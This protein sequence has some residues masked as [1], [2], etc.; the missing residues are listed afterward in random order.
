[1]EVNRV[2]LSESVEWA[3]NPNWHQREGRVKGL[4]GAATVIL[5]RA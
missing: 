4:A 3:S 2:H 1:M 5:S